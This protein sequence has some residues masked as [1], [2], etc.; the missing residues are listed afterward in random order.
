MPAQF[1]PNPPAPQTSRY[2]RAVW[3]GDILFLRSILLRPAVLCT[4]LPRQNMRCFTQTPVA[5]CWK[6]TQVLC[7]SQFS[8]K[9]VLRGFCST[10]LEAKAKEFPSNLPSGTQISLFWSSLDHRIMVCFPKVLALW[11]SLSLCGSKLGNNPRKP[12][13]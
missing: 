5:L 10:A 8:R 13:C 12:G 9:S 4:A 7:V 3:T 2:F 1:S 11:P 6:D